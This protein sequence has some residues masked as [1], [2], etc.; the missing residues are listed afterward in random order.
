MA[1]RAS[2]FSSRNGTIALDLYRNQQ[3]ARVASAPDLDF[4][5]SSMLWFYWDEEKLEREI[6]NFSALRY[7]RLPRSATKILSIFARWIYRALISRTPDSRMSLSRMPC[8]GRA[9]T[10]IVLRS[11]PA[12]AQPQ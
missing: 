9:E 3:S 2:F 4:T 1:I 8:I 5:P 6:G 11:I 10:P 12:H 7:R